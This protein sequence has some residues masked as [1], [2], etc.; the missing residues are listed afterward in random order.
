MLEIW[1]SDAEQNVGLEALCGNLGDS[2]PKIAGAFPAS[3][4][5]GRGR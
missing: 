2:P 1:L 3:C 4:K 5:D